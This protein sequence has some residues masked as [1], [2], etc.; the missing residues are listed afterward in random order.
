MIL[1]RK[2][3]DPNFF[4]D[5]N[6]VRS[7]TKEGSGKLVHASHCADPIL[8]AENILPEFIYPE[9]FFKNSIIYYIKDIGVFFKVYNLLH[10]AWWQSVVVHGV[11]T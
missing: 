7:H 11:S 3:S 1:I 5:A 10:G 9:D 6:K 4:I 8:L 2:N